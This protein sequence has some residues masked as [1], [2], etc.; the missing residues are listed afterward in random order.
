MTKKIKPSEL[1]AEAQ[2]LI[3]V[4]QMPSLE[5]LLQAMAETREK[6]RDQILAARREESNGTDA[7]N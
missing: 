5:T 7:E 3:D 6:Y 1:E 2:R 4:G